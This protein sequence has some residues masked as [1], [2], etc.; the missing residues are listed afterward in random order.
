MNCKACG[1]PLLPENFAGIAD[2]CPCNSP[3]GV[4]HGIVPRNTCTCSICDP[5]QTGAVRQPKPRSSEPELTSTTMGYLSLLIL[6]IVLPLSASAQ[7][8]GPDG[9]WYYP[10]FTEPYTRSFVAGSSYYANGCYHQSAGYYTY[11]RYYPPTVNLLKVTAPDFETQ[12][13][14]IVKQREEK[15]YRL[16][17]LQSLG[18]SAYGYSSPY[19]SSVTTQGSTLYGYPSVNAYIRNDPSID[20]NA[21]LLQHSQAVQ[22]GIQLGAQGTGG[23]QALTAQVASD[24]AANDAAAARY[25]LALKLIDGPPVLKTQTQRAEFT[26]P[27]PA[28]QQIPENALPLRQSGSL[29]RLQTFLSTS[30]GACHGAE[31]QDGGLDLRQWQTFTDEQKGKVMV[32]ISLPT[33][34]EKF[35]P[36]DLRDPSKP[37]Q[38]ARREDKQAVLE[39]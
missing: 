8:Q 31:K 5:E 32:R 19:L 23:L 16:K 25:A 10:G 39:N 17:V 37:G 27:A 11:T 1:K 30:C 12:V 3:R 15:A 9:Y 4:N 36:R 29:Q 21:L 34:S 14:A 20:V 33:T 13:L 22:A 7:S 24:K 2:G 26:T 35:M 38:P 28:Q 18:V 6:V